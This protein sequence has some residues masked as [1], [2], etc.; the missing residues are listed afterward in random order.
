VIA[1]FD[2]SALIYLIEAKEPFAGR[3]RR[4]L[5]AVMKR[6]PDLLRIA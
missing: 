1:F 6:Y 2:A 4:E 5:T 3:V